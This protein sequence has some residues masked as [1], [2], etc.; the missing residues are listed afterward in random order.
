M[1]WFSQPD[2]TNDDKTH[3]T[4]VYHKQSTNLSL[5]L[6][7]LD[8]TFIVKSNNK[9]AYQLTYVNTHIEVKRS[10][11]IVYTVLTNYLCTSSLDSLNLKYE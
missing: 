8:R 11:Q 10:R 1:E 9:E 5:L 4:V 2:K 3:I 7:L 6:V